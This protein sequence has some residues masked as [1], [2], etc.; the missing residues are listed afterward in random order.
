MRNFLTPVFCLLFAVGAMA[1]SGKLKAAQQKMDNLD[2]IGAIELYNQVLEKSDDA[3]AKINLAEAYRKIN[4]T[5][6][7]EFWYGQV[8]RLPQAEPI[9]KLY[10][11]MMLQRNGKCDVAREWFQQF[12]D[13]APDDQ[14][15]AHL[16]DACNYEEELMTK[17]VSSYE[18][19]NCDFNSASDDFSPFFYKNGMVFSSE[20][21]TNPIIR[22]THNWTGNPFLELYYIDVKQEGNQ[23]EGCGKYTFGR[24]E[25]FSNEINTKYHD[26][27]VALSK[28]GEEIFFTRNNF[29]DGKKEADDAGIMRLKIFYAR[30]EGEGKWGELQSL[31]FNSNEYSVAHPALSADGNKLYFTS[32]M[33]GGFGGMDLY[34]SEKDA[35]RWGPPMNLGPDVNTEGHEIFP[36]VS[37]DGRLY[38]ASDGHVGL[39]GLDI[40][41]TVSKENNVWSMPENLGY[42]MNT[43][44]D[45]FSI[46]FN[47]EGTCGF[48]ASDREGGVGHD[49]IYSFKK[50]ALNVEVL[51]FDEKTEAPLEDA[52]VFV[53][54]K[55]DS[56]TTDAEGKI[57]FDLK[58]NETC[59]LTASL[60]SYLPSEAE[61]STKNMTL[62]D[63]LQV[64]I[65]MKRSAMFEVEGVVFDAFTSLPMEGATVT[66]ENDCGQPLAEPF[67]TSVNGRYAFKLDMDCCYKIKATMNNYFAGIAENVCTKDKTASEV[68]KENLYLQPTNTST[69]TN[70]E[71]VKKDK[72]KDNEVVVNEKKKKKDVDSQPIDDNS[73]DVERKTYPG[74]FKETEHTYYDPNT[75]TYIDKD[76]RLP[77]HGKYPDGSVFE[78]GVMKKSPEK[79]FIPGPVE[80]GDGAIAYLLHIYYDFDQASIREDAMP[81][82]DKLHKLMVENPQYIIEIGSHT[83]ARGSSHYNQRLSQRRAESV[84]RWLSEKGINRSRLVA[85]GYGET[86]GVNE[87]VDNVPCTEREH[88]MNRRTEFKVV[89]C[90]DCVEKTGKIVSQQNP[91]VKVDEC[92]SCPF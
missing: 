60:E 65:P 42:P 51:V 1:Q 84:V 8:V 17:A 69:L 53:A 55:Q 28:N 78:K 31:P 72:T 20:R 62:T 34:L 3:T 86:V 16:L 37:P 61:A 91:N 13:L 66:L 29:L 71:K 68:L 82:L 79:G 33:P 80:Q 81:E 54:C 75:D 59:Q 67:T 52:I 76:T 5:P 39:G 12:V 46:V 89:G 48:L 87:C 4:D 18:I 85:R 41:Y 73:G 2:Y 15:G 83:D 77:A 24:P 47:E 63:K 7:A 45:D 58:L 35:G 92:K 50:T 30:S 43:V 74:N 11:G 38:F 19:T 14:R 25:K 27:S 90:T 44:A 32:D 6:N 22:R 56:M 10:Y 21:D 40:F 9:H 57:K 36:Y 49:D 88:Q 64:K 23:E 70:D 26:A